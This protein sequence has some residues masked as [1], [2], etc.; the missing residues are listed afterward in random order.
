MYKV[1]KEHVI[2]AMNPQN[3]PVLCVDPKSRIEFETADCFTDQITKAA[4][5]SGLDW[6]R[7]NP[8]TGPVYINGAEPGDILAVHIEAIDIAC[9]GVAVVG[10]GMGVLG[11]VLD[12]TTVKIVDIINGRAHF[13]E[14]LSFPLN[15]MI[16]VIGTS[17]TSE[18][19][20]CGTPCL[21][22]G[23]MDCKEITVGATLYLPVNRPGALLA[24]G[25]LHGCM[26]DGE[27]GV[28][29]LEVCGK[30]TVTVDVIKG[31]SLPLPMIINDSKVMALASHEDLDEAVVMATN[32]MAQ[33]ISQLTGRTLDEAALILS[34]AGNVKICQVVDPK[35]TVRMELSKDYLKTV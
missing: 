13:D 9:R 30:V 17:P 20:S 23:N 33:Y 26:G 8:A 25:D 28:S 6:E 24:M 7:I 2:Y 3:P 27:I 5:F 4:D 16:G 15:K 32:N 10:K 1:S 11:H 29:G 34:L 14:H 31:S 22:G 12:K 35:K 21:H 19:I 18:S